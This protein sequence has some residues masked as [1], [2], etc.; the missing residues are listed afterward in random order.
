M[1]IPL[2]LGGIAL[3]AV[4]Y[5]LREYCKDENCF[6]TEEKQ[7]TQ[8]NYDIDEELKELDALTSA[9]D[10]IGE[11]LDIISDAFHEGLDKIEDLLVQNHSAST[12]EEEERRKWAHKLLL[13]KSLEEIIK[14]GGT[15]KV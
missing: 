10:E 3:A 7:N 11:V 5:G 14:K 6:N 13:E 9:A 4:G 12:P 2:A 8:E 15:L 1:R